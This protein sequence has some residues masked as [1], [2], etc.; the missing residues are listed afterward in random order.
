M[1]NHSRKTRGKGTSATRRGALSWPPRTRR[2][3]N[4]KSGRKKKTGRYFL[5]V[6]LQVKVRSKMSEE[7]FGQR[8]RSWSIKGGRGLRRETQYREEKE[9][10]SKP[11]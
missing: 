10:S 8:P 5:R 3:E 1:R 11:L 4:K 7:A 2:R 9:G 6:I